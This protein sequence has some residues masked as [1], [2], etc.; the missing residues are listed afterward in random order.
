MSPSTMTMLSSCAASS[1]TVFLN[2]ARMELLLKLVQFVRLRR[3][4]MPFVDVLGE[5]FA[6]ITLHGIADE[7]ANARSRFGE[8]LLD[9]RQIM[10]GDFGHIAAERTKALGGIADRQAAS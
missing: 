4:A 5:G 3:A 9:R 6:A 7:D 1:E 8:R 10:A 2:C